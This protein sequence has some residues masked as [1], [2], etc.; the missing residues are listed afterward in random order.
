MARTS[1]LL[2]KS[3]NCVKLPMKF[4]EL[5]LPSQS[6]ALE[7]VLALGLPSI[8]AHILPDLAMMKPFSTIQ[9]KEMEL[10]NQYSPRNFITQC[11]LKPLL[12]AYL[13]LSLAL[14][15]ACHVMNCSL[16][17]TASQTLVLSVLS[18]SINL[19]LTSQM[20][21]VITTPRRT[22]IVALLS[23]DLEKELYEMS[24]LMELMHLPRYP[25]LHYA[26]T[27]VARKQ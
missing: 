25:H 4:I 1:T 8:P 20:A 3:I 17:W 16:C 14:I 2:L 18:S 10:A 27:A 12:D 26:T 22:K 13:S 19:I 15:A 7:V 23:L 21:T 11:F 24:L 5:Q 6:Q 9:P